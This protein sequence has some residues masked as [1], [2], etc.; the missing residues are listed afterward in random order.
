MVEKIRRVIASRAE[1]AGNN[2]EGAGGHFLD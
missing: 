1:E 2:W